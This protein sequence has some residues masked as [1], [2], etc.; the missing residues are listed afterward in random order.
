MAAVTDATILSTL[1]DGTL[2]VVRAHATYRE[3]AK[4]AMRML[5]DVSPTTLGVVLNA[6]DLGRGGYGNYRYHYYYYSNEKPS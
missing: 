3:L 2:L 4:Q 5:R 1:V 6:T